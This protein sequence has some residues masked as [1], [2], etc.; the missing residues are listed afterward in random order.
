M[1]YPSTA[2]TFIYERKKLGEKRVKTISANANICNIFCKS[3]SGEQWKKVQ[4]LLNS[5]LTCNCHSSSLQLSP[6]MFFAG[7]FDRLSRSPATSNRVSRP[8]PIAIIAA[9]RL[10]GTP[11]GWFSDC[12]VASAN[13]SIF[14]TIGPVFLHRRFFRA[15]SPRSSRLAFAKLSL[16][17]RQRSIHLCLVA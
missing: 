4:P 2:L 3:G 5:V 13:R 14:A 10:R 7:P 17:K 12:R 6:T 16:F 1:C 15:R 11:L 8:L 9:K